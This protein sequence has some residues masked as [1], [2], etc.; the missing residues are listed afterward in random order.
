MNTIDIVIL[1]LLLIGGLNGLR[2]GF[3]NAFA[4]LVGWVFALIIAAKYSA[5]FA[6]SMAI[7]SQDPVVQKIAAFAFVV[8]I[9]VVLTWIVTALLN[10]ILKTFKLGP[11][12]RL[13]GGTLGSLKGLFIVLITMQ[14]VG[15]WVEISPLWKQSKIIQFLLPYAPLATE[16]SK[17]AANE[18]LSHIHSE[19]H[20]DDASKTESKNGSSA[21][22]DRSAHST[23]N[24]F[25]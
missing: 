9:I 4:N 21:Q 22:E 2:K 14:G 7:L 20:S 6:P 8:L 5:I 1:I 17:E 24:P 19:A 16:L 13:A 3:V 10:R 15:P 23:K 25:Y 11:L 12:N 18:A